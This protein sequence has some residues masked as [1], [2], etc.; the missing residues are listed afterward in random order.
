MYIVVDVHA[1]GPERRVGQGR[2]GVLAVADGDHAA[3]R[4]IGDEVHGHV[5]EGDRDHLVERVGLARAQV[6]GQLGE[7]RLD[8]R[9][10]PDLVGQ[11]LG[12]VGL[13][14]VAERVGLADLVR[15]RR[16][17]RWRPRRR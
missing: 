10:R 4:A 5:G 12:H 16:P 3:A 14:A 9:P 17:P 15:S 1:P 2:V 13:V 8:A 7:H 6:V 11:D